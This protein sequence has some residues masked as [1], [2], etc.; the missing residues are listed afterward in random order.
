MRTELRTL[1]QLVR[2]FAEGD[3]ES[4]LWKAVD[5]VP[6]KLR[7]LL[8][9]EGD[10]GWRRVRRAVRTFCT[11]LAE[12]LSRVLTEE[13]RVRLLEC[14]HRM[15]PYAVRLAASGKALVQAAVTVWND[16]GAADPTRSAAQRVL[17]AVARQ[18]QSGL[19]DRMLRAVCTGRVYGAEGAARVFAAADP[20]IAYR[21]A[22]LQVQELALALRRGRDHVATTVYAKRLRWWATVLSQVPALHPLG[23]PHGEV[24]LGWMRLFEGRDALR[25]RLQGADC[26]IEVMNAVKVYMPVAPLLLEMTGVKL[27][28]EEE[29]ALAYRLLQVAAA[30]VEH[31]A[32][33]EMGATLVRRLGKGQPRALDRARKRIREDVESALQRRRDGV[34]GSAVWRVQQLLV[35]EEERKTRE[36][37]VDGK[38]DEVDREQLVPLEWD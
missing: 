26:L 22:F 5:K 33:P 24:V 37:R 31:P 32:F 27:P 3:D 8:Q 23:F 14:A 30:W 7:R 34:H 13:A 18:S 25:W 28:K 1:R 6:Y 17:E 35:A 11:A 12:L 29:E 16:A 20:N 9:H 19:V 2:A 21:M 38:A 15:V 10:A 36:R 4:L